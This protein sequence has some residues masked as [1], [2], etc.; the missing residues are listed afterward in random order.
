M[1]IPDIQFLSLA[2]RLVPLRWLALLL[3]PLRLSLRSDG[4]FDGFLA[5]LLDV[6][7]GI[8]FPY[9]LPE[10]LC[11]PDHWCAHCRLPDLRRRGRGRC[12]FGFTAHWLGADRLRRCRVLNSRDNNLLRR[13][14]RLC[15]LRMLLRLLYSQPLYGRLALQGCLLGLIGF[16]LRLLV[17]AVLFSQCRLSCSGLVFRR[18][19][20]SIPLTGLPCIP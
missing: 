15:A 14:P 8:E 20:R 19:R 1:S 12:L 10:L 11:G 5:L 7:F 18:Q 17:K 6:S 9:L 4:R 16:L 3:L 2:L 13:L